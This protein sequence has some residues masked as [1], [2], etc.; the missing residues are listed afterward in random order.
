M[1]I[2]V[3]F[4][5]VAV[6]WW[7]FARRDVGRK[8]QETP[9][10]PTV[11]VHDFHEPIPE[12]ASTIAASSTTSQWEMKPVV[13]P[14]AASVSLDSPNQ[15]IATPGISVT[16]KT[17]L[18]GW[19]DSSLKGPTTPDELLSVN[20]N[21]AFVLSNELANLRP[22]DQ[23][24]S[25]DSQTKYIAEGSDR[26]ISWLEPF[27]PLSL[28]KKLTWKPS[29]D[30][31]G[32]WQLI[33]LSKEIRALI[34]LRRKE[35]VPYLDLLQALYG[36]NVL[37]SFL[38]AL[39]YDHFR[40]KAMAAYLSRSEVSGL[41]CDYTVI[42]YRYVD[43][44]GVTDIK[45]LIEAFGEPQ[46][47]LPAHNMFPALRE[48]AISRYLWG[49]LRRR[50]QGSTSSV[51]TMTEFLV[52]EKRLHLLLAKDGQARR[53]QTE[54]REAYASAAQALLAKAEAATNRNFI[55]AELGTTGRDYETDEIQEFCALE[56]NPAGDIVD[57]F[58]A[59][60]MLPNVPCIPLADALRNFKKFARDKPIFV[61]NGYI[62]EGFLRKACEATQ[63]KLIVNPVYDLMELARAALSGDSLK[64]T[65]LAEE[66][67]I[68]P[69]DYTATSR[70][71]AMVAVL[72]V[73]CQTIR[74]RGLLQR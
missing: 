72:M 60:V 45:W 25:A 41:K 2:I 29:E 11:S 13:V 46:S 21:Y 47:H 55:V 15:G 68:Q 56:V 64:L 51:L 65:D 66:I 43:G 52:N 12:P 19:N 3:I 23:W 4:A 24:W 14:A 18:A 61:F 74:D 40:A 37:A 42:G 44:F 57:E 6:A 49:E 39:N 7:W 62:P 71:R 16:I 10:N 50:N 59:A 32:P 67:G 9:A 20:L 70:A 17:S 33:A 36:V 30:N 38:T 5:V 58:S 73:S 53:I 1:E 22:E 8:I 34:R 63:Q 31:W 48:R 69:P 27:V 35:K 54:K 28:A 26:A